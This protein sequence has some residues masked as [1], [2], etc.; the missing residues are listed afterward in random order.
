MS[1]SCSLMRD[2]GAGVAV[3][4]VSGDAT[5]AVA[6]HPTWALGADPKQAFKAVQ[7]DSQ[8]TTKNDVQ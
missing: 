8:K 1:L 7:A 6:V 2:G 5:D 4:C 3:R